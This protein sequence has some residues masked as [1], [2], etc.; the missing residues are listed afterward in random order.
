M[1]CFLRDPVCL[2]AFDWPTL[3]ILIWGGGGISVP[4]KHLPVDKTEK[5]LIIGVN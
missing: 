5:M 4:P 2:S 3:N 1:L